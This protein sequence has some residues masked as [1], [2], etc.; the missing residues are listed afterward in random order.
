MRMRAV[1]GFAGYLHTLDPSAPV[2]P[3]GLVPGL[4]IGEATWLD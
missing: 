2:P 4:G 3:A 1:R